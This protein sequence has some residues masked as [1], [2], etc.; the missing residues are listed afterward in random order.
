MMGEYRSDSARDGI[1]NGPYRL[2]RRHMLQAAMLAPAAAA[3]PARAFQPR[4]PGVGDAHVHLFNAADLPIGGFAKYV[5]FG[6]AAGNSRVGRAIVDILTTIAQPLAVGAIKELRSL[7]T[8]D[9]DAGISAQEFG[10]RTAA[11][12]EQRI[13]EGS[14]PGADGDAAELARSHQALAEA[15]VADAGYSFEQF[16]LQKRAM[17]ALPRSEPNRAFA[18]Q[19]N[20]DAFARAVEKAENPL[21][22]PPGFELDERMKSAEWRGSMLALEGPGADY[23]GWLS[24][25]VQRI[26]WAK[27]MMDS[28]SRHLEVFLRHYD[29]SRHRVGAVLNHLVDYD[30]W[31]DDSP[32]ADSGHGAQID[33]FAALGSKWRDRVRIRTFGGYCPLKHAVEL[34]QGKEPWFE[35]LK[36]RHAAG[37]IAGFKIY[38]PMGFRAWGNGALADADFD[39]KP[40]SR[41]TA[42]DRWKAVAGDEPLG[43]ALDAA[44][45]QFYGY[46][47]EHGIPVMAHAGPG[48]EAGEGYGA[49]ANPKYWEE[50]LR[51]YP[52]RLSLGHLINEAKPFVEAKDGDDGHEVWFLD[53]SRRMLAPDF[54]GGTAYG[55]LAYMPELIFDPDL[56]RQFFVKLKRL[57]EPRDPKLTRILYG[58]DWIMLDSEPRSERMLDA[59][60]SAMS[61]A[62]YDAETQ[63]NIL[64]RNLDRF[65]SG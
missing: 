41:R 12:V 29:G 36:R 38:P 8:A 14:A 13:V 3:L 55:D 59:V 26:G 27:R 11:L 9:G 47:A 49:R 10:S 16:G 24:Y 60:V 61:A 25:A 63:E 42:L 33:F 52:L 22:Q 48:N 21:Y 2:P 6:G 40:A 35:T 50:V 32:R 53:A 62:G 28:R 17:E 44:L 45:A 31:L 19:V 15:A 5:L 54:V 51:R 23:P 39:P 57:L 37:D 7:G 34:R 65:L 64:H 46:C 58:S 43:A 18:R 20:A 1:G 30:Y 56:A 4:R